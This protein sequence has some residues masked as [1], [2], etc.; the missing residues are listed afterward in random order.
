MNKDPEQMKDI[1]NSITVYA[2]HINKMLEALFDNTDAD[3]KSVVGAMK[4]S[5]LAGGKRIRPFLVYSVSRALCGNGYAAERFALAV[6]LVHTYS[7]IHDDMP[8][9]DN[10]DYRRG[11]PTCHKAFGESTAMLAGDALLTYAFDIIS[12]DKSL[13][14]EMRVSAVHVLSKYAGYTGMIGG[15]IIDLDSENKQISYEKLT[16]M[17]SL[18]TGAL[19]R[20]AC[21]LGCISAGVYEGEIYENIG[22]YAEGIGR[23]FQLVDDILDVTS[24]SE[25]LGKP[26]H[27]DEKN[28]KTTYLSFMPVEMAKQMAGVITDKAIEYIKDIDKEGTLTAL[29]KYLESRVK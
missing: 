11:K 12:G 2:E 28:H 6:E 13:P 18:K 1:E 16:K 10:D 15:Q 19:I 25:E 21:A 26:T 4:Y 24:T 27:S 9:M 17:H 20:A 29:A 7:L 8:C 22:G 3:I 23:A 14:A 5:T